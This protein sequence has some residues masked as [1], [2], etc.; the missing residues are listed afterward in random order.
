MVETMNKRFVL[1]NL[2]YYLEENSVLIINLITFRREKISTNLLAALIKIEH[3]IDNRISL[4]NQESIILK[5]LYNSKQVLSKDV[6]SELDQT[7]ENESEAFINNM[8]KFSVKAF[9]INLTHECNF[10]CTYCYQNKYKKESKYKQFITI[11]DIDQI[12]EYLEHNCFDLNEIDEIIFSG[13]ESLLPQ[14]INTINYTLKNIKSKKF[15]IFTNG[16]NLYDYR[17]HIDY[18]K[19]D[20]FQIS[21]DGTAEIIKCVNHY[22]DLNSFDKI[23][24]GIKYIESLNKK[25]SIVVIWTKGLERAFKKFCVN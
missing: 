12:K 3:K 10:K 20:E 16:V 15:K 5:D 14:N 9:V 17:K 7:M 22:T 6:I 2:I 1:G 24:D 25:N 23:I 19:I 8:Y 11:K 21:L 4:S 13:G 18:R